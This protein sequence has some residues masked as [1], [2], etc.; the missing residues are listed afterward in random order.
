MMKSR[1]RWNLW[2][3]L[4]LLTQSWNGSAQFVENALGMNLE[5][6]HISDQLMGGGVVLF[7]SNSDGLMD[8]YTTGGQVDDKLYINEGNGRFSDESDAS[9]VA[10]TT[11][12]YETFGVIAGDINNDGC[13]DLFVT[14]LADDQHNLLL[15][16]GCDGTYTDI[17]ETA[18]I[19]DGSSSTS[20]IFID[21][22]KDSFLD[23]YVVNY[24]EVPGAL[25]NN[26]GEI[27]GFDH[28]CYQNY[29]YLNNGDNTFSEVGGI[30]GVDNSGCG[31]AAISTDY[32][33]D[34]D[35]DIYLANDFGEW[36]LPNALYRNNYPENSFTNV[37]VE[38]GMDIGLYGMGI[39]VGD[40]DQDGD[41]DYY[42]TNLGKNYF[43]RNDGNG[44]FS[45]VAE[46]L[47]VE[48]ENGFDGMLATSWGTFFLDHDNDADLD[49]FVSNGFIPAANF[50]GT[51]LLD[52]NVLY[53]NRDFSFEDIAPEYD[54]NNQ[55]IN[56][57]IAYGDFD[58]DGYAD[59]FLPSL[60][61]SETTQNTQNILSFTNAGPRNN[62]WCQLKIQ[63]VESNVDAIGAV[64]HLYAGETD[65]IQETYSGGTH[66][67][68]SSEILQFGLGGLDMVDSIKI[69]WP[70]GLID[71][72]KDIPIN[73]RMFIEEGSVEPEVMGCTDEASPNYN[74]DATKS[75][76]CYKQETFGCMAR[77]PLTMMKWLL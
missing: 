29:L 22:N 20:A 38:T 73:Q 44:V 69:V 76:G 66:A 60:G 41:F 47:M 42:V 13:R 26:D 68:Q 49:L 52:E 59:V 30:M 77:L 1:P 63:G 17:S 28:K 10:G 53:E 43:M 50:I 45:N 32:D 56:R 27:I 57:G 6:V 7:D 39:A 8:I 23:I 25:F 31:L 12:A 54:L 65:F 58:N 75:I 36:V 33:Q 37:S 72:Y 62:N 18:G 40:Y 9:G 71:V 46:E 11:I 5:H 70:S 74:P 3:V 15:L 16:N 19:V 64:V 2:L 61:R 21:Y 67:S 24:I 51:T 14:T 55:N 48:N 4:L 34:G 35:Q